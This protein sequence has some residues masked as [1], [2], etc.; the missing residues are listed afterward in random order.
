M[1]A[2]LSAHRRLTGEQTATIEA[3]EDAELPLPHRI[4]LR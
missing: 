1:T 3:R 2:A 4:L